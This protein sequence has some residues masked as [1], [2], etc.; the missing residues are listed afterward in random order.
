MRERVRPG[1]GRRASGR[2]ALAAVLGV[3]LALGGG[4]LGGGAAWAW[5]QA[6]GSADGPAQALTAGTVDVQ[7]VGIGDELRGPGGTVALPA[8]SLSGAFPGD[9]DSEVVTVRNGGSRA[10]T[11]TASTTRTGS[12][13]TAL[14]TAVT[15]GGTDDGP[16]CTSGSGSSTSIP[17]GGTAALCVAVGLSATAPSTMQGQ[18]GGVAVRLAASLPGTSWTDEGT[19]TS[20]PVGAGSVPATTLRCGTLGVLAVTFTW[21]AVPGAARYVL[22]HG[23]GGGTTTAV[24]GTSHTLRTAVGGGTAWVVVQRDFGSVTWVSPA[25]NTRSYTVAVASLCS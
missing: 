8:L 6:T 13:A 15:F 12:I 19:I 16:S 17:A 3:L 22:H 4:P 10:V 20:G 1:G 21:D 14:T 23:V 25:S 7:V 24:T 2:G 5:W 9:G 11:V 18:T